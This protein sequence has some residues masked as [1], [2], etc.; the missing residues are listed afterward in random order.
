MISII[1]FW[2]GGFLCGYGT[3]GFIVYKQLIKI[4]QQLN[5]RS[6]NQDDI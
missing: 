4:K 1:G 6:K 3:R 2:I 5:K